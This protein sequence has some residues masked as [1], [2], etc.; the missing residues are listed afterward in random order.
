MRPPRGL[1]APGARALPPDGTGATPAVG[2]HAA[3]II[4]YVGPWV[5]VAVAAAEVGV[6]VGIVV[7]AH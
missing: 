4:P 2:G 1:L 6:I 5:A 7:V 3:R